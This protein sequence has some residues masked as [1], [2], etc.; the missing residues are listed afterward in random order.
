MKMG[1][2]IESQMAGTLM[3]SEQQSRRASGGGS[4]FVVIPFEATPE[5]RLILERAGV[6]AEDVKIHSDELFD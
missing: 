5:T 1:E 6:K 2:F 4:P 3:S